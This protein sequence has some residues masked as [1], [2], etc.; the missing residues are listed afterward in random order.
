MNNEPRGRGDTPD[1]RGMPPRMA[2]RIAEW[3][4]PEGVDGRTVRGDLHEEYL[5]VRKRR[6]PFRAGLWYWRQ[7]LALSVTYRRLPQALVAGLGQDLRHGFRGLVR[8]PTLTLSAIVGMALVVGVGT[9]IYSVVDGVL[10]TPLPFERPEQLVR[11]W[12]SDEETGA[13][14]LDFLYQDIDWLGQVDG[15]AGV[16]GYSRA[17]RTL[18]TWM[19]ESPED[20]TVAR[21]TAGFFDTFG[22]RPSVGRVYEAADAQRERALILISEDLWTRRY[23]RDP[24]A[25]GTGVHIDFGA[26]EIVGVIPTGVAYPAD[27]DI[28]RALTPEEMA[29]DDREMAVVARLADGRGTTAAS[30]A[31]NGAAKGVAEQDPDGHGGVGAWMQP[32]RTTVVRDVRTALLAFVGAVAL[33]LVITSVNTANLMLARAADRRHEVAVR[34]SLGAGR[35]RI[36]RLHLVESLMLAA[37]GGA[38]GILLGRWTLKTLVAVSPT[39]PRMESVSL[40]VRVILVMAVVAALVGVV[41]GVVPAL[42]AAGTAPA[43]SLRDGGASGPTAQQGRVSLRSALVTTE[44]AM[45]TLLTAAA[46]LLFGTFQRVLEHERGFDEGGLVAFRIDPLHPPMGLFESR[47]FYERIVQ[48]VSGLGSVS[49]VALA[50]HELLEQR[51]L[52][53]DVEIEGLLAPDQPV[54]AATRMA[55]ADLFQV[56]GIP[57]ITGRSFSVDGGTDDEME[58]VVNRQFVAS[59]FADGADPLGALVSN[60]YVRG[61]IVGV[62]GDVSPSVG[63]PARPIIYVPFARAPGL[64][65]WMLVRTRPGAPLPIQAVWDQVHQVDQYMLSNATV[66]LEET[67]RTAA[68][69]QR[70]NM[71]VVT[72]FSVLALALAAV[73]IY[74]L[75]AYSISARRSELGIRRALGASAP[76]VVLPVLKGLMGLTALGVVLGL[77]GAA[78]GG[79]LLSSLLVGVRWSDPQVLL[80]VGGL[81]GAVSLAAAALPLLRAVRIAPTEAL[82][83]E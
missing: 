55:T 7:V 28:W 8:S 6:G 63:E 74:G 21:T 35:G 10:L 62:V 82:R 3:L 51:G 36:A 64:T 78:V 27:A 5:E 47:N 2:A 40:D 16:A 37:A 54:Q 39:I 50:S 30:A 9:A 15:L 70:F 60:E 20:V 4:L 14:D 61:R 11:I 42:A 38:L 75:T 79:R 53:A 43:E 32:L 77:I 65:S 18:L 66:V 17:P 46:L 81:L 52:V 25:I 13:R 41:S 73:G 34:N 31:L 56:S 33:L 19:M 83:R 26:Y 80:G 24:G 67:V 68:A 49:S 12:A 45:S 72:A 44:I 58:L 57:L 76:Q 69:P 59:L 48:G 29:D 22:I 1:G 23:G 71:M